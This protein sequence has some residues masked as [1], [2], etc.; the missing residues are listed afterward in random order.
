MSALAGTVALLGVLAPAAA[1]DQGPF[2]F[3]KQ[4]LIIGSN[5]NSFNALAGTTKTKE[6]ITFG[7]SETIERAAS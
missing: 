4:E 7:P 2:D 6:P 3:R 1:A 5:A